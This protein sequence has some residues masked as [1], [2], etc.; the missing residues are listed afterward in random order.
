MDAVIQEKKIQIRRDP[1]VARMLGISRGEAAAAQPLECGLVAGFAVVLLAGIAIGYWA[2]PSLPRYHFM[3]NDQGMVAVGVN[4][5][6]NVMFCGPRAECMTP[7]GRLADPQAGGN[8]ASNDEGQILP[9][10]DRP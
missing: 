8:Q 9:L 1:A 5:T 3:M 4:A 6:G 2:A 7:E 10:D